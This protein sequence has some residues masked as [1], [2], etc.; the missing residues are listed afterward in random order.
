MRQLEQ[1]VTA[2]VVLCPPLDF[3]HQLAVAAEW[4]TLE[5]GN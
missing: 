5:E 1:S 2:L 4:T 3:I